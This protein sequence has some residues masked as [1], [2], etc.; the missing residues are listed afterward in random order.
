MTKDREKALFG[1]DNNRSSIEPVPDFRIGQP[2]QH[3]KR[4]LY[5]AT[6]QGVTP[7]GR[8]KVKHNFRA[9]WGVQFVTDYFKA[10][11][12]VPWKG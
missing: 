1:G 3:L 8:I 4:K 9:P 5:E 6:Y 2:V 7:K 10:E 12:I 11:F